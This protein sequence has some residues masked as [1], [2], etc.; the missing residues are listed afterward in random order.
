MRHAITYVEE[1]SQTSPPQSEFLPQISPNRDHPGKV[2]TKLMLT[3]Q[4]FRIRWAAVELGSSLEMRRVIYIMGA[5]SKKINIP[6]LGSARSGIE[7]NYG[8]RNSA[9]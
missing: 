4:Y 6:P 9:G 8:R 2:G 5:M 7:G 3:V 1:L